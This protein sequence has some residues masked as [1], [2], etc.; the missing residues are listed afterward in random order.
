MIGRRQQAEADDL[1]IGCRS[2]VA[3]WELSSGAVWQASGWS[4][5]IAGETG[6]S[7]SSDRGIGIVT[8][9]QWVIDRLQRAYGARAISRL[10]FDGPSTPLLG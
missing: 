1:M 6:G 8:T 10:C 7:G 3:L 2:F 5:V 4:C 9:Q